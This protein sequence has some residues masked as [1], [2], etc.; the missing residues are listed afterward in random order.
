MI[1]DESSTGMK[2]GQFKALRATSTVKNTSRLSSAGVAELIVTVLAKFKNN[3]EVLQWCLRAVNNLAKSRSMK[4]K[5]L[6]NPTF[7]ST[8]QTIADSSSKSEVK[9]WAISASKTLTEVTPAPPAGV[10]A[11]PV[12]RRESFGLKDIPIPSLL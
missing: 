10:L 2:L 5:L 4:A 3:D 12:P 11:T 6:E 7:V 9:Y 1:I 8:I